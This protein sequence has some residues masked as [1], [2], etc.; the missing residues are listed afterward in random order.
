[1]GRRSN[2]HKNLSAGTL[3]N[4]LEKMADCYRQR[5]ETEKEKTQLEIAVKVA[6]AFQEDYLTERMCRTVY[7]DREELLYNT[8]RNPYTE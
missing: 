3:L 6:E 7:Q 8:G 1:M 5:G 4:M 2:Q